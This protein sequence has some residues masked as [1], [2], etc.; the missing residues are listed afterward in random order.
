MD[1][2]FVDAF[3]EPSRDITFETINLRILF[4]SESNI[5]SLTPQGNKFAQPP[6]AHEKPEPEH[7]ANDNRQQEGLA[8]SRVGSRRPAQIAGRFHQAERASKD[9]QQN[10]QR[11]QNV[12]SPATFVGY[13]TSWS[14]TLRKPSL[15]FDGEYYSIPISPDKITGSPSS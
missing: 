7:N 6:V 4:L 2:F 14:I 1:N 8:H 3:E 15:P 5:A 12:P 10:W 9:E 11:A 13:S